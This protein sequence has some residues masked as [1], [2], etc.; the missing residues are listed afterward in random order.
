MGFGALY[1]L[2]GRVAIPL[3]AWIWFFVEA[4]GIYLCIFGPVQLIIATRGRLST[5]IIIFLLP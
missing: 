2:F 3:A 1:V 4:S 5:S